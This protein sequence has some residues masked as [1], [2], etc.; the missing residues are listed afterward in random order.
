[1]ISREELARRLKIVRQKTKWTQEAVAAALDVS[2]IAV[3]HWEIGNNQPR[4]DMFARLCEA[5]GTKPDW[6]LWR[7]EKEFD[8]KFNVS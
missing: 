4:L 6:F 1:M 5:Y 2:R 7:S 8:K 3:Y